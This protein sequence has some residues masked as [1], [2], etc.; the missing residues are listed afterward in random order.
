MC[1]AGSGRN[2]APILGACAA[3]TDALVAVVA[4]DRDVY[5]RPHLRACSQ[6]LP[7]M[8]AHSLTPAAAPCCWQMLLLRPHVLHSTPT[9]LMIP[10]HSSYFS[11]SG[12]L[13]YMQYK[14][15]PGR[16]A[17]CA[18]GAA[19]TLQRPPGP[20][21]RHCQWP[22]TPAPYTHYEHHGI[23]LTGCRPMLTTESPYYM[24][25]HTRINAGRPRGRGMSCGCQPL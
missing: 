25:V 3:H 8:H 4:S 24:C 11:I 9:Q 5:R 7:H 19:G 22:H 12:A 15:Q 23:V 1:S 14:A 2:S 13:L 21:A 18:R 16:G 6:R 20:G 10:C 17:P